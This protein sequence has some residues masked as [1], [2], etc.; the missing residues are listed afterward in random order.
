MLFARLG[1]EE[2]SLRLAIAEALSAL[3]TV[4]AF[5]YSPDVIAVA[6]GGGAPTPATGAAAGSSAV[7]KE[8]RERLHGVLETAAGHD[9]PR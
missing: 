4:Y 9:E 8:L 7:S 6:A 1:S 5:R 3:A 2:S